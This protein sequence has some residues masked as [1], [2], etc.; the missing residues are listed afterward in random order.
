M[1]DNSQIVFN[2]DFG[3]V[4]AGPKFIAMI[5]RLSGLQKSPRTKAYKR[6]C[7]EMLKIEEAANVLSAAE[8]FSGGVLEKTP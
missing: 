4:R 2:T 3:I 6:A 1:P 5:N 8:W 7:A